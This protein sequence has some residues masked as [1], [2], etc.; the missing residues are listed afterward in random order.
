VRQ[1][2]QFK[3]MGAKRQ[4]HLHRLVEVAAHIWNHSIA[5]HRTYYR[6]YGKHLSKARLQAHLA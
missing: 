3:L 6:L 2:F 1:A 4:K 5:V